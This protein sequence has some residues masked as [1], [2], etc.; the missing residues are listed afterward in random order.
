MDSQRRMILA[1][2]LCMAVLFIWYGVL[3]P[4]PKP[5]AALLVDGG[6]APAAGSAQVAQPA[7]ISSPDAG[8]VAIAP[9]APPSVPRPPEKTDRIEARNMVIELSSWGGALKHAVLQGDRMRR[10]VDGKD[11]QVDLVQVRPTDPL[12]L[13]VQ[14]TGLDVPVNA[15]Y[16]LTEQE[17]GAAFKLEVAGARIVKTY[18]ARADV[19]SL[20][21]KVDVT[22]TSAA[23]RAVTMGVLYPSWVNPEQANP[24][25]GFLG[26]MFSP[27]PNI[28]TAICRA[29]SKTDRWHFSKDHPSKEYPA[30]VGW[31]GIDER[32]FLASIAPRSPASVACS[33]SADASGEYQVR[34]DDNLGTL[35]PGDTVSRVYTAYL[36][37]KSLAVLESASTARPVFVVPGQTDVLD[38]HEAVDFSIWAV[39]CRLLLAVM[40]FFQGFVSNWG[41]AIVLLTVLVKALLLPLTYRQMISMEGMRKLQPKMEEIRKKFAEDRE[42]MNMEMMKLYQEHKVNPLGGCFPL[43]LQMPVWWA[44]YQ[45]LLSSFELYRSSFLWI[46]DLTSSDP[47]FILPA[48]MGITMFVTQKMQ[49]VAG[50]P[51]QAKVMLYFMPIFFTFIM[52]NLP[53]G[54]TLYI[55]TNNLLSI[56]QQWYLRRKVGGP[57][58]TAGATGRAIVAKPAKA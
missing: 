29:G 40:R 32:Y 8:A 1:I 7:S 30:P 54:L 35:N 57:P 28:T 2:A 27:R 11:G 21:L 23:P 42:R 33:M 48:V 3:F 43:L 19:Y 24:S 44:L 12:P 50:D 20:D 41:I 55:F 37:P 6:L 34:L 16:D 5:K 49:P 22:N 56:A 47:Y 13:S 45:T 53:S 51:T 9:G 26:R 14:F 46:H 4:P 36:G 38:L 10:T 58:G 25:G 15:A 31:A 17:A 52:L 39:I 18:A